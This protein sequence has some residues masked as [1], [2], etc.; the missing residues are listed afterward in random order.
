MTRSAQAFHVPSTTFPQLSFLDGCRHADY[1]GISMD[2]TGVW[3]LLRSVGVVLLLLCIEAAAAADGYAS[4]QDVAASTDAAL[5]RVFLRGGGVI[6][7]FGEFAHVSDKVVLS[8]PIGGTDSSPVLHMVTIPQADVDW[9]RTNAY[10]QAAR[11][12]RY[13]DTRGEHDFAK[14]TREVAD[15]L[16]Q[17]G[18]VD[19]P[20][21]RVAL[22]ESARK[23]LIEW[24]RHHH[25]YRADELAHMTSWLDQVVSELRVAA[26]LSRFDLTLVART[27]T[28]SPI[29]DLLPPP[30]FRERAELGLVAARKTRDPAERVSLLRAVLDS[31]QAPAPDGT[32]MAALHAQASSELAAELR[33]DRAYADLT[34]KIVSRS[35]GLAERADVRGLESLIRAVFEEDRRLQQAR[36]AEVAGLLALL[37][38]RIDAAR[39]LRLARDAWLL[40][41]QLIH[42]YSG[43]IR[44]GLERL[45]S[46]RTWLTDVRQLAGPS[47]DALRRVA[48]EAQYA[49]HEL[50]KVKAP[51]EVA[52]VHSSLAAA[53]SMAARAAK[54]R[55]DALRSGRMETAWEASS[56]AAGALMLLDEAVKELRRVTREPAPRGVAR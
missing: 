10:A 33:T 25:G 8:I 56:A 48:Y 44:Q 11:A 9:E 53:C 23:Q 50:A 37:D 51:A 4:A 30:D 32:W 17:A 31:L 12:R 20:A 1:A 3:R 19:D 15:V 35:T 27:P 24:P 29:P 21:K 26:G 5:Y 54:A 49:G 42:A 41:T 28:A 55:L 46:V 14:L 34:N 40:R 18:L 45:L 52:N 43:Q 2:Q 22:A 38:A 39:R 7:S 47:P 13:A 36:P 6:V 16:Y